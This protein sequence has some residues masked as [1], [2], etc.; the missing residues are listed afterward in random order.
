M[1]DSLN[2]ARSAVRQA[3]RRA[4]AVTV[5]AGFASVCAAQSNA[6]MVAPEQLGFS[7]QRLELLDAYMKRQ[8]QSGHI[9]GAVTLLVR[10]GKV[11]VFNTYGVVDPESRAPM[12]RDTIFRIY[13]Q[14]KV[15]TGVAMMMLFEEGK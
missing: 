2:F 5:L 6:A 9:P 15:V 8:V 7:G 4:I 13:S 10:H 3:L 11:A 1:I 12:T 14:S